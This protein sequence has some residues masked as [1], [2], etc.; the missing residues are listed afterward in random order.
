MKKKT[1]ELVKIL[2]T[3]KVDSKIIIQV[4]N[5][6]QNLSFLYA[7]AGLVIVGGLIV[8]YVGTSGVAVPV[9]V[10]EGNGGIIASI[11]GAFSG[12]LSK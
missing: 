9:M 4:E 12:W 10:A 1:I 11:I 5:S 2:K 3:E 7:F 6:V 8:A